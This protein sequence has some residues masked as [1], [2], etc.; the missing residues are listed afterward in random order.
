MKTETV[1]ANLDCRLVWIENCLGYQSGS[2]LQRG[3]YQEDSDLVSGLTLSCLFKKLHYWEVENSKRWGLLGEAG[4][5]SVFLVATS[6][7]A[8]F[9]CLVSASWIPWLSYF[10]LQ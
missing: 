7:S 2:V 9:L 4:L 5:C 8:T 1:T 6:R 10:V 3:L